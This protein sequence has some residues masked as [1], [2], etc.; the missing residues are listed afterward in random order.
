[1]NKEQF[2]SL[3]EHYDTLYGEEPLTDKEVIERLDNVFHKVMHSANLSDLKQRIAEQYRWLKS[4]GV[5]AYYWMLEAFHV[6]SKKKYG[7]RTFNYAVGMLRNWL[8]Y[9]FGYMPT[10]EENELVEYLEEMIDMELSYESK[11][12]LKQYMSHFGTI[13]VTRMIGTISKKDIS[14]AVT[15]L[16]GDLLQQKFSD[17][18][19]LNKKD[20]TLLKTITKLQEENTEKIEPNPTVTKNTSHK[21]PEVSVS[22]VV[23][24]HEDFTKTEVKEDNIINVIEEDKKKPMKISKKLNEQIQTESSLTEVILLEHSQPMRVSQLFKKLN[25]YGVKINKHSMTSK[26]KTYMKYN[27]SIYRTEEGLYSILK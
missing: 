24:N 19:V 11:R 13:K 27:P 1:L 14:Y 26:L 15:L 7:K 12:L 5:P 2:D 10:Q 20:I 16:L 23:T 6:T 4:Q 8:R 3:K 9:G 22:T 25:D 21:I 18:I 17:T